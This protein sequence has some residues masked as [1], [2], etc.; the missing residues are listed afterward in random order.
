V[1]ATLNLHKVFAGDGGYLEN[2]KVRD[3]DADALREAREEIRATLRGAFRDWTKY[4]TRVELF[5]ALVMKSGDPPKLPQP[6][7][8]LQGSFAYHTANDPQ[9]TPPQ[10]VDQDD[11]VFLPIGFLAGNG[12]TRPAIV[13]KAYFKIV[14]DALRPLCLQRGWVLNPGKAKATCVRVEI[15]PRIHID[16]PLYAIR[17]DAFGRL[18][19]T[20]LAKSLGRVV[21]MDEVAFA[22][23]LFDDVYRGL[24]ETEIMLAHREE[25]WIASDPRK[26]ED[27][28]NDALQFFGPQVRRM[29]RVYK[30][31][32]DAAEERSELSSI[33]IMSAVVTALE[34]IGAQEETRD[35]L[36]LLNTAR[37]MIDVLAE[38]IE[39]PAFPGDPDHYL[40]RDWTPEVRETV[41]DLFRRATDELDAAIN[42]TLVRSVALD[43]VRKAFGGRAP[44]DTAL[45]G[46]LGAAAVIRDTPPA[47]QPQPM[48]VR[49]KSG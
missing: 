41:R 7:F 8:R 40:C 48:T 10:Q 25:D 14:E 28:F 38:P 4:V 3:E 31:M 30:G 5:D 39:H 13:S 22:E 34:N 6:K 16:L 23:D 19:E 35:D 1:V 36:A 46:M 32:R 15:G 18:V 43:H 11:G 20:S 42:G 47:P 33:G 24:A 45:V 27:W 37:E 17:D 49:T 26:V 29:S 12:S 2:L 21:A 44:T 9:Q